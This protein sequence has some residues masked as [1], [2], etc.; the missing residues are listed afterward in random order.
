MPAPWRR[1]RARQAGLRAVRRRYR[2]VW[3]GLV[4]GIAAG[5]GSIAFHELIRFATDHLLGSIAAYHPPEPLGEGGSPASGPERAWALPIVIAL[6]GLASGLLT[7]FLAPEAAGHGTDNAIRAFH[8]RSGRV[9]WHVVPI[10]LVASAVTIGSG[11]AAGPEGP[12]AQ[13]GAGFGSVIADRLGLEPAERRR[14]MAA[15]IGAGIGAIF[16]AP[17]GGAMM[18][19]EVLYRHDL[20]A[21]VILISLISSITAYAI[22]GS[23]TDFEPIFGGAAGFDFSRPSEL[24]YYAILGLL[25][26]LVGLLFARGFSATEA[27]FERLPL[28]AWARP[29]LGGLLVGLI[30]IAAPEAIHIGYGWVQQGFTPEGIMAF[31]PW[32]LLALPFLRIVTTSL[33][34]G[35]GGSG[36]IFGPGM[37]IGGMLGAA[38]WRL[39]HELPGFPQEP[40]PVVIIGMTAMFG[41]IAHVPLAMLLM[42]AEMTGNLS[43]LAPAMAAV[44][45]ATLVVGDETIYR[46]QLPTRAD[47][48]AHRHRF[49]FPLLSA[50]PA[51]QAAIPLVELDPFESCQAAAARLREAGA[52][53]ATTRLEHG[54][55]GEVTLPRLEEGGNEPVSARATPLPTAVDA[56]WPL[57]RALDTLAEHERRWLPVVDGS[58]THRRLLGQI[59]TRALLRSYR[60]A[61]ASQV[62]PLGTIA[63]NLEALDGVLPAGSPLA[64][65]RL[66]D[67]AFPPGARVAAVQRDGETLLPRGELILLPGDRVT[68]TYI[69]RARATVLALFEDGP[70]PPQS[71]A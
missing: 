10:K 41:A 19:A 5:L 54:R 53:Y 11:G 20:E 9:P 37:V 25:A 26:G 43:L 60:R 16:R 52:S 23:Y 12:N 29:A 55:L 61:A 38:Y 64:F 65:R 70:P 1:T 47:S 14:A 17:L 48:P 63:D 32:L 40:G 58:P 45:V 27:R 33:T 69:P 36:G 50:L 46:Q 28:P 35:S 2:A 21:D 18:A 39:G 67:V 8:W 6:G 13:I 4:I 3:L 44:A 51:R 59:D 62:R 42:V 31:S 34:V 56:D 30:G 7:T 71:R 49:A 15:G 22:F 57:D 66:A 24:P 68:V